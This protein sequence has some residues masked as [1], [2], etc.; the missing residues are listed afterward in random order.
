VAS[1]ERELG[2]WWLWVYEHRAA[3]LPAFAEGTN[4]AF[5]RAAFDAYLAPGLLFA[6]IR[7]RAKERI[8]SMA[9]EPDELAARRMRAAEEEAEAARRQLEAVREAS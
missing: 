9:D 3:L 6:P 7:K 4:A 1:L 2:D 5:W 8:A